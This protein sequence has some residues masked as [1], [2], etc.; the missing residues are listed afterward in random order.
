[1]DTTTI[2]FL[3]H[4]LYAGE[5]SLKLQDGE[6]NG[7]KELLLAYSNLSHPLAKRFM[8][9]FVTQFDYDTYI[10]RLEM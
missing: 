3:A 8:I 4:F 1:M 5:K 9:K 10:D 2:A 6:V 7:F